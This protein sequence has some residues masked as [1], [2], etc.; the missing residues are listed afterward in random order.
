MSD[1]LSQEAHR[2]TEL[3]VGKT[4]KIVRRHRR[5]ELLVEFAGGTRLFVDLI[6]S[7]VNWTSPL[8]W[9]GRPRVPIDVDSLLHQPKLFDHRLPARGLARDQRV[10]IV[11]R[12]A[13]G[14]EAELAQSRL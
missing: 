12:H 14:D 11:D 3:L 4:V 1:E 9:D 6:N 5:S 8:Q 7:I 2:M 10:E 13:V